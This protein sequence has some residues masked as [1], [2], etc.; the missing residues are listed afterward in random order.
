MP[1]SKTSAI[2]RVARV[3][4]ADRASANA[5]GD[6]HSAGSDVDAAWP[7]YRDQALA[8]LKTLREPDATM[9]AAGDAD[10]W[11]K[12]ALAAIGE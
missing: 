12:M 8:V 1:I 3:L 6:Q 7:E 10:V 5:H 2:E 9:A 4:A 11:E